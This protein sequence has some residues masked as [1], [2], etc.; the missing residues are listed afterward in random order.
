MLQH[1]LTKSFGFTRTKCSGLLKLPSPSDLVASVARMQDRLIEEADGNF[2]HV[3]QK[4]H[5]LLQV[6]AL[7]NAGTFAANASANV[8][9]FLLKVWR[10]RA[11][12]EPTRQADLQEQNRALQARL[13][14]Y[15]GAE[16]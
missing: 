4:I 11:F 13:L 10:L 14:L 16:V 1:R 12:K 2:Q 6:Q 3:E 9:T 15:S 8:R 7:R 5:R